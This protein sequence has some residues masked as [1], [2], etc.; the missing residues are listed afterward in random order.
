MCGELQLRRQLAV[1]EGFT[2]LRHRRAFCQNQQFATHRPKRLAAA[3]KLGLAYSWITTSPK[4]AAAKM[5]SAS[6]GSKD[7]LTITCVWRIATYCQAQQFAHAQ[8][9]LKSTRETESGRT[10]AGRAVKSPRSADGRPRRYPRA[11]DREIR[12]FGQKE[13]KSC[14]RAFGSPDW[15]GGWADGRQLVLL[16]PFRYL[17]KRNYS[18]HS[19]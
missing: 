6:S 17:G 10:K 2:R 18:G 1:N 3:P 8:E 13:G 15:V 4:C 9:A 16:C 7:P 12:V 5:K 19:L 11:R 14:T